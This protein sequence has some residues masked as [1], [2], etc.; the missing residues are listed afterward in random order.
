MNRLPTYLNTF[1][2]DNLTA[3]YKE[4]ILVGYRWYDTKKIT[5]LYPFGYGLSYTT[6]NYS[7]LQTDKKTYTANET[8]TVTIKVKNT[9][10]VAGKETVQLYVS[11]P[12]SSVERA[13]K[14]LKAFKKVMIAGRE[15]GNCNIKYS[16]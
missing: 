16:G 6:F 15:T 2:G 11:K 3:D 12:G 13:E 9:G 5:P 1:P 14:E 7:A 4:G 10:K 8:I